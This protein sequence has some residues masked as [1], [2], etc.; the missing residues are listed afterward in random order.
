MLALLIG[1]LFFTLIAY[2]VF[3]FTEA[4]K[5]NATTTVRA[6]TGR[7]NELE[8]GYATLLELATDIFLEEH[9]SAEG[10]LRLAELNRELLSV[11]K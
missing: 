9:L 4:Y 3:A 10:Q 5:T 11:Q 2:G 7:V 6:L 8:K 1:F